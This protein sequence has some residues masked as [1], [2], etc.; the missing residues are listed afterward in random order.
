MN[1]AL[2]AVLDT[3]QAAHDHGVIHRDLKPENIF[4]EE[5]GAIRVFDFGVARLLPPL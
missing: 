1:V 4:I 5:S 2:F 3:V